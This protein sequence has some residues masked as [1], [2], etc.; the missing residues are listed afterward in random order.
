VPVTTCQNQIDA[1][2][3]EIEL[4]T[5]E[6][7]VLK[8]AGASDQVLDVYRGVIGHVRHW[9]SVEPVIKHPKRTLEGTHRCDEGDWIIQGVKGELY[10]CKPDIFQMTYEELPCVK[11]QN[12]G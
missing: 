2:M 3:Q 11:E 6:Y 1:A 10:P 8:A 7:K 4:H 12:N 5:H 9:L